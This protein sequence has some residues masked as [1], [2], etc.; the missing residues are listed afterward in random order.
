MDPNLLAFRSAVAELAPG[1]ENLAQSILEQQQQQQLLQQDQQ[2]NEQQ[3]QAG[4]VNADNLYQ[5]A[6]AQPSQTDG[7]LL[8][9]LLFAPVSGRC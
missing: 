3:L 5:Q 9:A 7:Q 8:K 1:I 2:Q 6:G 4:Q